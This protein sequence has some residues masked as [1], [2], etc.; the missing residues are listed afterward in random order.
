[1]GLGWLGGASVVASTAGDIYDRIVMDVGVRLY[2]RGS[3]NSLHKPVLLFYLGVL[4]IRLWY[5]HF[6]CGNDITWSCLRCEGWMFY[7]AVG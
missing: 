6:F 3:V 4:C 1:V 5:G 2:G 7:E